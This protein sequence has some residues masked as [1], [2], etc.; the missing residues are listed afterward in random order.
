M[1]Q[2]EKQ[3][4]T[5]KKDHAITWVVRPSAAIISRRD[6]FLFA[7]RLLNF[8]S[9]VELF[10]SRSFRTAKL[11]IIFSSLF[12]SVPLRYAYNYRADQSRLYA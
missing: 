1:W 2:C 7:F 4:N 11:C 3:T 5:E 12:L 6:T 8:D 10:S 9:D